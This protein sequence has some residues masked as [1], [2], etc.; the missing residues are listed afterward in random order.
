MAAAQAQKDALRAW[1]LQSGVF[2][3][4][5]ALDR[6]GL[7]LAQ[8]TFGILARR[9]SADVERFCGGDFGI[10]FALFDRIHDAVLEG[11]IEGEVLD[12]ATLRAAWTVH[13]LPGDPPPEEFVQERVRAC[14]EQGKTL[15]EFNAEKAA[16]SGS[17]ADGAAAAAAAGGK[18]EG[19]V[20]ETGDGTRPRS[21]SNTAEPDMPRRVAP[22][23]SAAAAA[24][25][26]AA[27]EGNSGTV[28]VASPDDSEMDQIKED[29]RD[30]YPWVDTETVT[31]ML[32]TFA[33][34]RKRVAAILENFPR[35]G[36]EPTLG[37]QEEEQP[38][39]SGFSLFGSGGSKMKKRGKSKVLPGERP[40]EQDRVFRKLRA[41]PDFERH[42]ETTLI[43]FAQVLTQ[44][45]KL[46]SQYF[47][48]EDLVKHYSDERQGMNPTDLSAAQEQ[49]KSQLG[50]LRGEA[51][52]AKLKSLWRVKLILTALN[53]S[54]LQ[55]LAGKWKTWR[56][57]MVHA[58]VQ[59]GPVV[60]EW[61]PS[62][63]VVPTLV[64]QFEGTH[65]L[66]ALDVGV[67]DHDTGFVEQARITDVCRVVA[68][69]NATQT[70]SVL[71]KNCQH[72]VNDVLGALQLKANTSGELEEFIKSL[73]GQDETEVVFKYKGQSFTTHAQLDSYVSGRMDDLSD[74]DFALLKA[75]DRA[76]WI[77]YRTLADAL[78]L[79]EDEQVLLTQCQPYDRDKCPFRNPEETGTFMQATN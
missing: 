25:A 26:G 55:R 6:V 43:N 71:N 60:L 31:E 35:P 49:H 61:G 3:D 72:F 76:F 4:E 40:P 42:D 30:Q 22:S 17:G 47:K 20:G 50:E 19:A 21:V 77:R 28:P 27:E 24:A 52:E 34:D 9:P 68:R 53:L 12:H 10:A 8:M 63:V 18:A 75:Y 62:S 14:L 48:Q 69:W 66:L 29:L 13:N 59:V 23:P 36:D 46:A 15:R 32:V 44:P 2:A 45:M 73:S 64:S 1:L 57:G 74:A 16:A 38:K 33:G 5:A 56:F 70:Y 78:E 67:L 11:G 7:A 79:S 37:S 58:A 51:L 54:Q 39:K 65:V 41:M